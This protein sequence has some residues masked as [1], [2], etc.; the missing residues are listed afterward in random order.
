MR[1]SE[2]TIKKFYGNCHSKFIVSEYAKLKNVNIFFDCH[3]FV[4]NQARLKIITDLSYS[5]K[6]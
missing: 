2:L 4:L 6:S 1:V 3:Q 5:W